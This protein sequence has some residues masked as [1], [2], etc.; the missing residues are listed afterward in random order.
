MKRMKNLQIFPFAQVEMQ[1]R[2]KH[3]GFHI[4]VNDYSR[5]DWGWMVAKVEKRLFC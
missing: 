2:I 4:K 3:L 5:K 1:E